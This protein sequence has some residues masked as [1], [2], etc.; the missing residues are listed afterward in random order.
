[1]KRKDKKQG[2]L[3]LELY[4]L[5]KKKGMKLT[6]YLRDLELQNELKSSRKNKSKYILESSKTQKMEDDQ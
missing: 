6:N 2:N 3:Q 1:M 5:K 4:T